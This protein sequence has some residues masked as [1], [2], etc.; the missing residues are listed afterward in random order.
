M[1][2]LKILKRKQRI[3]KRRR[4]LQ[5][6]EAEK[7]VECKQGK[8]TRSCVMKLHR[9]PPIYSYKISGAPLI[10]AVSSLLRI[11]LSSIATWSNVVGFTVA[12]DHSTSF[13]GEGFIH[14][15][16]WLST[17]YTVKSQNNYTLFFNRHVSSTN[18]VF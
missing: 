2:S 1:G 11:H 14:F 12:F 15:H 13:Q 18:R 16:C 6:N 9:M 17:G 5:G 7:T 8:A 10:R 3:R 4:F